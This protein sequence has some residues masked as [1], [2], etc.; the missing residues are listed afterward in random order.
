MTD[1]SYASL[2]RI[3]GARYLA[4]LSDGDDSL[5]SGY[6]M[7][8][9]TGGFGCE[10]P[11][12]PP[13]AST[14]TGIRLGL[15][16]YEPRVRAADP[17]TAHD[18]AYLRVASGLDRALAGS[19]EL[20]Y[21]L[22]AV[23]PQRW[24]EMAR[25]QQVELAREFLGRVDCVWSLMPMGISTLLEARQSPGPP[26]LFQ[27]GPNPAFGWEQPLAGGW[28]RN[29]A[30]CVESVAA[31]TA[32]RATVAELA[33]GLERMPLG[34]DCEAFRPRPSCRA[35]VRRLLDIPQS[36]QVLLYTGR[37]QE[38][39]NLHE[40]LHLLA[41]IRE[42]GIDATLVIVGSI[43]PGTIYQLKDFPLQRYL[44]YLLELT[45][46]LDLF[47]HIRWVAPL[48]D[49]CE[50][51]AL[52]S[53]A[54]LFVSLSTAMGENYGL[55]LAEALACGLPVFASDWGG[56][57]E[58]VRDG[59]TG[60]LCATR[61]VGWGAKP[62]WRDRLPD[63]LGLLRDPVRRLELGRAARADAQTRL[64]LAALRAHC[65]RWIPERIAAP[66]GPAINIPH[67]KYLTLPRKAEAS[68]PYPPRRSLAFQHYLTA[69]YPTFAS[70][71]GESWVWADLPRLME[72]APDSQ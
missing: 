17:T 31:E 18:Q 12:A 40:V 36:T 24:S 39:K 43:N 54:D 51:A 69:G 25:P 15:F 29:D 46:R 49:V 72:F 44:H 9:H 37:I 16:D 10:A 50:L 56:Y 14:P 59:L 63:L 55:A 34:I 1:G 19:F 71:V 22:A 26:L 7:R 38:E 60:L 5:L 45:E 8:R 68:G 66:A 41:A 21:A 4:H 67:P 61:A 70:R 42:S 13:A 35:A 6:A 65:L 27:P 30:L 33:I 48:H 53:S 28:Q 52:Y 23:E 62:L 58:I 20:D 2:E 47:E 57:R 3:G 11:D 32:I 64:S